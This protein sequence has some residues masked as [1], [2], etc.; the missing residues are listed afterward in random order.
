M[1]YF[2]ANFL[3]E[4]PLTP[5]FRQL[6]A[7]DHY[8]VFSITEEEYAN[9]NPFVGISH[10]EITELEGTKG[11]HFYAAVRGYRSAYSDQEGLEPDADALAKGKRKTKVYPT[12]EEEAAAILLMKRILKRNISDEYAKRANRAG[13]EELL[14]FVDSL[15]TLKELCFERERLIGVEMYKSQLLEMGLWDTEDDSRKGR[16][17]YDMG[18]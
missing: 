5:N 17:V 14:A 9:N 4:I 16:M 13:E 8:S 15:S 7:Y 2:I 18:F 12:P 11:W 1:K 6:V 10:E 3:R